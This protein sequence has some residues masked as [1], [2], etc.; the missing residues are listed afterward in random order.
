MTAQIPLKVSTFDVTGSVAV[1]NMEGQ[2]RLLLNID[3]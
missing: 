3:K 2:L 1:Y